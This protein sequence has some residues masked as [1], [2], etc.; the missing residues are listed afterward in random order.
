MFKQPKVK[1]QW[2]IPS[3]LREILLLPFSRRIILV[4]SFLSFCILFLPWFYEGTK[5]FNGFE[6]IP[7]FGVCFTISTIIPF[8][9]IIREIYWRKGYFF[10]ISHKILLPFF[11]S[12]GLYTLFL[13]T[14]SLYELLN[15]NRS[16]EIGI[17]GMFLFISLGV[18][19]GAAL[20]SSDFFPKQKEKKLI[21]T[22]EKVNISNSS[23]SIE[24]QHLFTPHD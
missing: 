21:D 7:L 24:K 20:F 3:F 16:A 8:Y 9:I 2:E 5:W 18:G 15:Y 12:I 22:P 6:K 14:F 10:G 11:L 1:K 13:Y 4:A 19:L 17:G 23:L